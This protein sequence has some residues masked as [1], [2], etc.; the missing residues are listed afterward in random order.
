MA[1]QIVYPYLS[2]TRRV[3][4]R[5]ASSSSTSRI[6][7]VP[8]RTSASGWACRSLLSRRRNG[9]QEDLE[10]RAFAQA[11]GDLDPALVLFDNAIDRCQA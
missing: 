4:I 1:S 6:V 10:S 9:R 5:T 3:V 11:A 7:S 2:N 8:P